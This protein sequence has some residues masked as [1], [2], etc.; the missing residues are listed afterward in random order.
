MTEM[1]SNNNLASAGREVVTWNQ[2][3]HDIGCG[4]QYGGECFCIRHELETDYLADAAYAFSVVEEMVGR[5]RPIRGA[6]R[7]MLA[8]R[9]E[10]SRR[11]ACISRLRRALTAIMVLE[12]EESRGG[13][14][15]REIATEALRPEA[16]NQ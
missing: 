8:H 2:A 1:G 5:L 16:N 15:A 11:A 4:S 3:E 7:R 9:Q 6:Y 13:E 12:G 14:R 10:L